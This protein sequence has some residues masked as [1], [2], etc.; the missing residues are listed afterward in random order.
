MFGQINAIDAIDGIDAIIA[1]IVVNVKSQRFNHP[2]SCAGFW[3]PHI[4]GDSTN[5]KTFKQF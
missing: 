1:V 3:L 4:Q 5:G 2:K